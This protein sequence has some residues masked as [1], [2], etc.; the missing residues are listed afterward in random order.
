MFSESFFHG[1]QGIEQNVEE[2]KVDLFF[3]TIS[4]AIPAVQ[5]LTQD[6]NRELQKRVWNAVQHLQWR[7][8]L[9]KSSIADVD[10]ALNMPLNRL[11]MTQLLY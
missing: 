6:I 1:S 9:Q 7:F 8:F 11:L 4:I 5:L 10:W 2:R 3:I